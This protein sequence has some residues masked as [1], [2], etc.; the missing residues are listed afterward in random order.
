MTYTM[1]DGVV[2]DTR[3]SRKTWL[4]KPNPW[5]TELHVSKDGRFYLERKSVQAG[6][7]STAEWVTRKQAAE[8][9]VA[10]GCQVPADLALE[11]IQ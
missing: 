1:P 10:N 8:W 5:Y 3:E 9:L 11:V 7:R 2:V 6:A 4:E